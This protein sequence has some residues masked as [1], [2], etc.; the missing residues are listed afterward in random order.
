VRS[1]YPVTEEKM[2]GFIQFKLDEDRRYNTLRGYICAFTDR[3]VARL[4]PDLTKSIEFRH[5]KNGLRRSMAGDQPH[6][7]EPLIA[8][9]LVVFR[10]AL[11]PTLVSVEDQ[12][13]LFLL[14]LMYYGFFRISEVL[15][16]KWT[17]YNISRR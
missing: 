3:F 15:C 5:F 13:F 12:H 11:C 6:A 17:D 4:L 8:E 2:R 14:S 7:K 1:E 16:L 10:N 9:D